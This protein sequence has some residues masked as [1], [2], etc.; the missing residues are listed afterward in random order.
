MMDIIGLD[1]YVIA[2][3]EAAIFGPKKEAATRPLLKSWPMPEDAVAN[4]VESAAAAEHLVVCYTADGLLTAGSAHKNLV[5]PSLLM[6]AA[7]AKA[8]G[9][10][11]VIFGGLA[12]GHVDC[13]RLTKRRSRCTDQS[14]SKHD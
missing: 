1:Q 9:E 11:S 13:V 2:F 10:E 6:Y 12:C 4:A 14:E 8:R 7:W 5:C 3:H